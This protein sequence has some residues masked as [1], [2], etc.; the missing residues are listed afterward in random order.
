MQGLQ[1]VIC[2]PVLLPLVEKGAFGGFPADKDI[3]GHSQILHQVQFLVDDADPQ[4]LG[5]MGEVIS[6]GLP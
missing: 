1:Q 4:L 3:F 6:V 2:H 5:V